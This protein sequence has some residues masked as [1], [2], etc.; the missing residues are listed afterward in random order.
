VKTGLFC[1]LA[2]FSVH[3]KRRSFVGMFVG[4]WYIEKA[5]TF[6]GIF[7]ALGLGVCQ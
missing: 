1:F 7:M 2:S 4:S 3:L 5:S 6:K